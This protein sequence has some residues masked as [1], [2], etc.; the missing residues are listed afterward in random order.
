MARTVK[1]KP[2]SISHNDCGYL[3]KHDYELFTE[4]CRE[5]GAMLGK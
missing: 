5:V 1:L 2:G 4:K 3:P